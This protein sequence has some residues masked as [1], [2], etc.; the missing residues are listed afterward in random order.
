MMSMSIWSWWRERRQ[1]NAELKD[2]PPHQLRG[3]VQGS[4]FYQ[5]PA[6]QKWAEWKVWRR[7]HLWNQP[8]GLTGLVVA[9]AVPIIGLIGEWCGLF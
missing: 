6:K 7:E 9:I 5:N 8:I 1:W 2:V 4:V 3:M